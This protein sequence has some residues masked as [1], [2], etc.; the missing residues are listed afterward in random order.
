MHV[1]TVVGGAGAMG[2]GDGPDPDSLTRIAGP[3]CPGSVICD[4]R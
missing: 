3:T 2:A 1:R 4:L